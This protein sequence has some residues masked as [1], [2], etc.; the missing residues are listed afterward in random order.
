MTPTPSPP[1]SPP[2][3]PLAALLSAGVRLYQ[4]AASGRPSP[5]RFVPT[6]SHYALEALETHGGLRGAGLTVRRLTRCNPWGPTGWDPVKPLA[7][8]ELSPSTPQ[9][10]PH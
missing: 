6:C 8:S 5:C 3:S 9:R 7:S 10:R 4:W 1:S 2:L